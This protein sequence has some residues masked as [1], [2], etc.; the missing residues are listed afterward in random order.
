MNEELLGIPNTKLLLAAAH[1]PRWKPQAAA[2]WLWVYDVLV[3]PDKPR[4]PAASFSREAGSRFCSTIYAKG[5]S[6]P[7]PRLSAHIPHTPDAL[8]LSRRCTWGVDQNHRF[9]GLRLPMR[10]SGFPLPQ[11]HGS[12]VFRAAPNSVPDR[13]VAARCTVC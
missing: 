5:L 12:R 7:Q 9:S 8:P 11:L 1:G 3:P 10:F 6:R 2:H 4:N 13:A